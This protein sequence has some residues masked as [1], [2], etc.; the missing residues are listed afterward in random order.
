ME[1]QVKDLIKEALD[2][3]VSG[4]SDSVMFHTDDR[5]VFLYVRPE[6]ISAKTFLSIGDSSAEFEVTHYNVRPDSIA[7][8]VQT[9]VMHREIMRACINNL[10]SKG[11][12]VSV[13][14]PFFYKGVAVERDGEKALLTGLTSASITIEG[15]GFEA[16]VEDLRQSGVLRDR[17]FTESREFFL[18]RATINAAVNALD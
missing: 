15:D 11:W 16:V 8:V 9:A 13:Y 10:E 2:S 3:Y 17:G 14:K 7:E 4:D 12:D 1:S 18:S 6:Y 5:E